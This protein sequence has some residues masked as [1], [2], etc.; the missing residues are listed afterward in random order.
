MI[1][2]QKLYFQSFK[3]KTLDENGRTVIGN[4]NVNA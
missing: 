3:K 2:N 4:D 1:S